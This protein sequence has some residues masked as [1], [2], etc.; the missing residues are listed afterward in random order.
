MLVLACRENHEAEGVFGI[1]TYALGSSE[2]VHLTETNPPGRVSPA[3]QARLLNRWGYHWQLAAAE[4][5]Y[6]GFDQLPIW[7]E[8]SPTDA[9]CARFLQAIIN[10]GIDTEQATKTA[11][12]PRDQ[13][14]QLAR[15]QCR[16]SRAKFL[17][18]NRHPLAVA[19][20]TQ[21]VIPHPLPLRTLLRNWLAINKYIRADAP[22]LVHSLHLK[23]EQLASRPHQELRRIWTF[24][25]IRQQQLR[26]SATLQANIN[27]NPN[28]VHERAYCQLLRESVEARQK[29]A[30][31]VTEFG[32]AVEEFGYR[33]DEW[34]CVSAALRL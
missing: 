34:Q 25:A 10:L 15:P 30:E 29:H 17:F 33:L 3:M 1:G 7:L 6:H 31:L 28:S 23:L 8:K 24:L 22:F 12:L 16:R 13:D 11:N 5:G 2:R 14:K 4:D 26:H 20:S 18:I 9:V 19:L 27:P 21:L 32:L